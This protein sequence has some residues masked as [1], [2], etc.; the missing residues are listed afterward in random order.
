MI[1]QDE[2]HRLNSALFETTTYLLMITD[3]QSPDSKVI[4]PTAPVIGD[5]NGNVRESLP[6][7]RSNYGETIESETLI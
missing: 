4:T 3:A 7:R 1:A 2:A 5:E 6:V